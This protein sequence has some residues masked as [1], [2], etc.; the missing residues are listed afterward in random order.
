M[1]KILLLMIPFLLSQCTDDDHKD[2]KH[3][4]EI[5][6]KD[7]QNEAKEIIKKINASVQD[8]VPA[9]I[10]KLMRQHKNDQFPIQKLDV[11][12]YKER[13][14]QNIRL[15]SSLLLLNKVLY[16]ILTQE[17]YLKLIHLVKY[18]KDIATIPTE[19]REKLAIILETYIDG[20]FPLKPIP[21]TKI[22]TEI[23]NDKLALVTE[24]KFNGIINGASKQ[25]YDEILETLE[26][27]DSAED[28]E[29]RHTSQ[30]VTQRV[31]NAP[32]EG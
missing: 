15:L 3:Q 29:I 26:M 30:E 2:V 19:I 7:V 11:S 16:N 20:T 27:A 17:D 6:K 18:D 23:F 9:E 31:P 13:I 5:S 14:K 22:E 8:A 28:T 12:M 10:L 4:M 21:T 25:F 1:K 24:T 32:E